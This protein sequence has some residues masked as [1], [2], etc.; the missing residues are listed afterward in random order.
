MSFGD[1]C[2]GYECKRSQWCSLGYDVWWLK[3]PWQDHP[4]WMGWN[5]YYQEDQD[6]QHEENRHSQCPTGLQD[7]LQ[8]VPDQDQLVQ[9]AV[10]PDARPRPPHASDPTTLNTFA[11]WINKGAIVQTVSAAQ[12]KRW[13]RTTGK[14]YN[15]YTGTPSPTWCKNVL[16]KKF[17]KNTIKMV[18]HTKTG[19]FMVAT[20]PTVQGKAFCFPK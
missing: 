8:R 20:T 16:W 17:G 12:V 15:T 11:N 19:S 7:V 2:N 5:W 3:L 14:T 6:R 18:A 10:Q 9:D 13:A 1:K 4:Y